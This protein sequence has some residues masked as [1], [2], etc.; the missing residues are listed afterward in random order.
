MAR[1]CGNC[2][3]PLAETATFCGQCGTRQ[4]AVSAP[5]APA[6]GTQAAAP[7]QSL[8]PP[9][10]APPA[11]P[12][13]RRGSPLLKVVA[14]LLVLFT[15]VIVAAIAGV[16]YIGYRAKQKMEQIT[17]KTG[18]VKIKLDE[19]KEAV[20]LLN[21]DKTAP[22]RPCPAA[23]PAQSRAFRQAAASASIPLKPG[24]T[25]I[26]VWTNPEKNAHD[27]ELMEAVDAIDDNAVRMKMKALSDEPRWRYNSSRVLCITDLIGARQYETAS[28]SDVGG[29]TTPGAVPDT[30]VGAT[31][32]SMSQSLFQDLK[33][34]RPADLE[35]YNARFTFTSFNEYALADDFTTTLQHVEPEDVPYPVIV[36]GERKLL[37][38]IHVA[39][40]G[41]GQ[42]IDANILDEPA[43]PI[44]LH[45]AAPDQ[46]S[47]IN[48]LKID[49]PTP[50][51][52]EQALAQGRC[53]AVSGVY[54]N[55]DSARL[56]PES[57]A[58]LGE[59]ARALRS[60]PAWKV[61]IEGH[62]DNVGGD[63]YNLQLSTQRAQAV[64]Q[65][66]VQ[67]YSVSAGRLSS[68]GFGASRPKATNDTVEGRA[69]NRRVEVCRQ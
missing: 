42:P 62:T 14:I 22:V 56:R 33:A 24:L 55:F 39:A 64:R 48:Y 58:A 53:V 35:Y 52:F 43:N 45:F 20:S 7:V 15:L 4:Q 12:P 63:A 25:L 8:P 68:A 5:A 31:Q 10:A 46:K 54:F 36:N 19:M 61:S 66:L 3:S 65:A 27:I 13:A 29:G 67:H 18:D 11:V 60:N 23:D 57:Q 49:F 32:F 28:G 37:P 9:S 51:K 59:I 41:G 21:P 69:L 44:T 47:F 6:A 30:I 1:F 26:S 17:A 38:T 2:G 40:T 34:G 50:G 16:V